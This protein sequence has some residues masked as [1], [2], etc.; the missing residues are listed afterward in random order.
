M[1]ADWGGTQVTGF[2]FIRFKTGVEG[3]QDA[4]EHKKTKG[5]TEHWKKAKDN[6]KPRKHK[7]T[8]TQTKLNQN[9]M[10]MTT[11]R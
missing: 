9:D 3:N 4:E 8:H 5:K 7:K 2:K 11:M 10:T 6:T 1:K